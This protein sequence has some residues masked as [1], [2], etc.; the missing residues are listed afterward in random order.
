VPMDDLRD[1]LDPTRFIGR[2]AAQVDEFLEE[3]VHPLLAG[4]LPLEHGDG[5]EVRV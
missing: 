1:A 3:V 4:T 2:S 5:A